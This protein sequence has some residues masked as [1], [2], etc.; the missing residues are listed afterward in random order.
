M[1]L[2]NLMIITPDQVRSGMTIRVHQKIREKNTKGEE[3]ERIQVFQ[4][5]VINI[6]GTQGHKTMTLRKI[7]NSVGVEKIFP[8]AL[9]AIDK[10]EFVKQSKV[11]RKLL[12]F[13]RIKNRKLKTIDPKFKTEEAT[14]TPE[15]KQES[16]VTEE[17]K[18][19][20]A[21]K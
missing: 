20:E 17:P 2:Q 7:S 6:R 13:I 16:P 9:P 12:S 15:V 19:K 18:E 1:A 4:G 14:E 21:Q 10:I 3:K 8:L 5:L 11:R